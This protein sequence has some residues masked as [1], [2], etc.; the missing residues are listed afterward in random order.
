MGRETV[1]ADPL[2]VLLYIVVWNEGTGHLCTDHGKDGEVVGGFEQN[3]RTEAGIVENLI[4][5]FT[6]R[7]F[8]IHHDEGLVAEHRKRKLWI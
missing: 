4:H 1:E 3:R 8:L 5:G 6:Y 2:R 7:R